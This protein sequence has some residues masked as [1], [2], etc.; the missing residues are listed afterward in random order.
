M[1]VFAFTFSN[2]DPA[3]VASLMAKAILAVGGSCFLFGSFLQWTVRK[4]QGPA[5]DPTLRNHAP[6]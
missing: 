2:L 5:C 3:S 6:R 4:R 1:Q